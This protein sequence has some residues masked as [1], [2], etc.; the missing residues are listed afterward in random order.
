MVS[1]T[2]K[3]GMVMAKISH[4]F[5]VKEGAAGVKPLG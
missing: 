5:E 1:R 3:R 4:K 2:M